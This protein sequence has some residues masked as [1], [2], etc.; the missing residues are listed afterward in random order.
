MDCWS[1][2][3]SFVAVSSLHSHLVLQYTTTNTK[4]NLIPSTS[5]CHN[6]WLW[7]H[8]HRLRH[9]HPGELFPSFP[10]QQYLPSTPLSQGNHWCT[11]NYGD[12]KNGYHYSNTCVGSSYM[13]EMQLIWVSIW[14]MLMVFPF[15]LLIVTGLTT[16]PIPM[17]SPTTTTVKVARFTILLAVEATGTPLLPMVERNKSK[18]TW[19]QIPVD[20]KSCY[21]VLLRGGCL[22]VLEQP[23]GRLHGV[24]MICK[25]GETTL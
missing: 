25:A 6:A 11:R 21:S 23:E 19:L 7:L 9:Q 22:L 8:P 10:Q 4:L 13:F 2:Y 16:T 12:G 20:G 5:I 18:M 1:S 17:E 24:S 14:C 15:S 3:S